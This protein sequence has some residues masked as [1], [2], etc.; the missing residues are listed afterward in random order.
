[1]A[2][3]ENDAASMAECGACRAVIPIDSTECPE[4]GTNFSGLSDEA[5]GECGACN[6]LVPLDSTQC[7]E[8]GVLF[9]ADDVV[10]ILRKW[11]ADT[12]I[13]IRKLFD[14]FDDNSDGTI[15]S[16]E[17][18][19]GLL[20]LNLADL[21]PSQ[22]DRLVSEID[23]D[24]NGLIDLDEF[25]QILMGDE[26]P[27][28]ADDS[29]NDGDDTASVDS[30]EPEAEEEPDDV[31]DEEEAASESVVLEDLS[32]ADVHEDAEVHEDVD[33]VSDEDEHDIEDEA[34]EIDEDEEIDLTDEESTEETSDE[35]DAPNAHH[36]LS[37]L[38]ALADLM[39]DHDISAQRLFNELDA[40]GNG[41]ISLAE[42]RNE[43][44]EKYGETLD[45]DEVDA[46][47]RSI[48]VDG[49]DMIDV[50]EFIASMEDYE[51]IEELVEEKVFPSPWQKRMMSKTWNDSVWPILH[52]G[53]G[54]LV[55][56]FIANGM[57]G[58]V[59]GSGGNI[60]YEPNDSGLIPSGNIAEGEIYPCDEKFQKDGC[61]NSLT[62]LAGDNGSLSMPTGFY[63]DG[64]LFILISVI[65]LG[66]TLFLHLVKAPEWR[67]RAKA[68][69]EFEQDKSEAAGDADDEDGADDEEEPVD[70]DEGESTDEAAD[71]DDAYDDE[72]SEEEYADE[73]EE[74]EQEDDDEIDIGS[75]IGLVFDDEEVFGTIVEF[76][77][78]E[79]TVTIEEDGTG[80][81]VTGYQEDMFVE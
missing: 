48:D 26:V 49:D 81:L 43:L 51:T 20:S 68:M 4:C 52:V 7:P 39:D 36:P 13:N 16:D 55:A 8:C 53:F 17:L 66:A 45:G 47:M 10:D 50:T 69:K 28:A 24:G 46:I 33:D 70:D 74:D 77:D 30:E 21:P 15:D 44:A 58:F 76:D 60:A 73:D 72:D 59:D 75:H 64:I 11:V 37:A 34:F 35:D 42:L 79:G 63:W 25:D 23:A 2:D 62:P 5:L 80:D 12:G 22:V 19:A 9:V 1:M 27:P 41:M 14:K 38:S 31:P 18:R 57:F 56:I 3:E 29:E 32:D 40:D 54:I 78:D 61:R 65:G 71:D 6:S 67:A